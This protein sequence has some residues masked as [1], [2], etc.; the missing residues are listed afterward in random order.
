MI[1]FL[2]PARFSE[3]AR[4]ES[5]LMYPT[6]NPETTKELQVSSAILFGPSGFFMG[7]IRILG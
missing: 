1:V 6:L 3:E 5:D 4:R 7:L 2:L